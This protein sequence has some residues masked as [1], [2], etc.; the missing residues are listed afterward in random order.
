MLQ[1]GEVAQ[2]GQMP[3]DCVRKLKRMNSCSVKAVSLLA[4]KMR[5]DTR[6]LVNY[7]F[8]ENILLILN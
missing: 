2:C 3:T 7:S 8:L 1:R 4:G 5:H 6:G